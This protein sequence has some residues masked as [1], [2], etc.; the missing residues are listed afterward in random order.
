MDPFTATFRT[1]DQAV[2][3][4]NSGEQGASAILGSEE[5]HFLKDYGGKENS[6]SSK[7]VHAVM[8]KSKNVSYFFLFWQNVDQ[9]LTV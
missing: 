4:G 7:P 2:A 8:R 3:A 6:I 9:G 5:Q 1:S